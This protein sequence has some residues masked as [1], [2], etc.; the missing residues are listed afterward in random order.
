MSFLLRFHHND[1][2]GTVTNVSIEVGEDYQLAPVV[3]EGYTQESWLGQYGGYTKTY[4]VNG[5][6]STNTIPYTEEL[7]EMEFTAQWTEFT[8]VF[9]PGAGQIEGWTSDEPYTR[10]TVDHR[11]IVL[12][13]ATRSS[14]DVTQYYE[15]VGWYLGDQGMSFVTTETVFTESDLNSE[16]VIYLNA[17]WN[18][19]EFKTS[20][21]SYLQKTVDGITR[22]LYLPIIKKISDTM[23]ASLVEMDTILFGYRNKFVMDMGTKQSF[24]LSCERITP[25]DYDD[26]SDDPAKFSN[27][28]WWQYFSDFIDFW[29]NRGRDESGEL[30]GGF[31]FGLIPY[32]EWKRDENL[33]GTYPEIF[34]NV[35]VAGSVSMNMVVDKLTFS[36][37][38]TVASMKV[39]PQIPTWSIILEDIIDGEVV[40]FE[41]T[42]PK[43]LALLLPAPPKE[44]SDAHLNMSSP[45]SFRTWIYNE[46][47]LSEEYPAGTPFP[48][49]SYETPP[50]FRAAWRTTTCIMVYYSTMDDVE[51]VQTTKTYS[52][53]TSIYAKLIGGGASG[54]SGIGSYDATWMV[55][56][57]IGGGGGGACPTVEDAAFV[58]EEGDTIT[59][60][61]GMGSSVVRTGY[62]S[63]G[64]AGNPSTV[65]YEY[66]G[67][68]ITFTSKAGTPPTIIKDLKTTGG[69]INGGTGAEGVPNAQR[70]NFGN[71]GRPY[72][73]SG[74]LNWGGFASRDYAYAYSKSGINFEIFNG[75][76][77]GGGAMDES[78]V[79][80]I[81][82]VPYDKDAD[83]GTTGTCCIDVSVDPLRAQT[84][85]EGF[86]LKIRSTGGHGFS[87][88]LSG[89]EYG[90]GGADARRSFVFEEDD[91]PTT[92]YLYCGA[93]GGAVPSFTAPDNTSDNPP[94]TG[95]GSNGCVILY[96]TVLEDDD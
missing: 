2:T 36:L 19:I 88:S 7:Q 47:D 70:Q 80:T 96:E 15:F 85:P 5:V 43:G 11:L 9:D 82:H 34:K 37:P 93:G 95:R 76:G 35:F 57:A 10:K 14:E 23:S 66:S 92:Y 72:I 52:K 4:G 51:Y 3:R 16:G 83:F 55:Y 27:A 64:V 50:V 6:F 77:G 45:Q 53:K 1:G 42:S 40:R 86:E 44:W 56:E 8:V 13:T 41:V 21:I 60:R 81:P 28:K 31:R 73:E 59:I 25:A 90:K 46:G 68:T 12:P 65:S 84:I 24:T 94:M 39:T 54:S 30:T 26:T 17:Y 32:R 48:Y 74:H 29:Q 49:A 38:L 87:D 69:S 58:V 75:G 67:S 78:H 89:K 61:V 63:Y 71:S 79:L 62:T 22:R 33:A 91:H 20:V 18:I